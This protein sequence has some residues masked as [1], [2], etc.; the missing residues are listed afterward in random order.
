MLITAQTPKQG[1]QPAAT[2]PRFHQT[3]L[4]FAAK[5]DRARDEVASEEKSTNSTRLKRAINV[6]I[7]TRMNRTKRQKQSNAA[8]KEPTFVPPSPVE[9]EYDHLGGSSPI[10]NRDD[11]VDAELRREI[12]REYGR[13]ASATLAPE[14]Q[15]SNNRPE[16]TI[17]IQKLEDG[18]PYWIKMPYTS[19]ELRDRSIGQFFDWY[20][21]ESGF[22]DISRLTVKFPAGAAVKDWII[23][24]NDE[25]DFQRLKGM[26]HRRFIEFLQ[27][28]DPV[29][30][31]E[32]EIATP[33]F[34][35]FIVRSDW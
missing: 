34:E 14:S 18:H 25:R 16:V 1:I 13:E 11:V 23:E 24:R 5:R 15:S 12:E 30:D 20:C 26:I 21:E 17:F 8:S 29:M 31:F 33:K 28:N 35:K 32:L 27:K 22:S 19:K 7:P 4:S 10:T 6:A 3:P 9:S 2:T